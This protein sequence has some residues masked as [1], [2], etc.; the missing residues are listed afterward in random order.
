M[1]RTPGQIN[2]QALCPGT[3]SNINVPS[4]LGPDWF[5][6]MSRRRHKSPYRCP[7]CRD[8]LTTM[9]LAPSNII[10]TVF[11]L[12][13]FQCPH[14][15]TIFKRPFALIGRITG[16]SWICNKL[17][18]GTTRHSGTSNRS[19]GMMASPT[20]RR[21]AKFGRW[22]ESTEE[23]IVSA[24]VNVWQALVRLVWF[25]PGLFFKRRPSHRRDTLRPK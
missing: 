12:R 2:L 24:I 21:A 25:L 11:L 5:T 7:F 22:V 13:S 16:V 3:S 23:M 17:G 10:Q 8:R 9:D 19:E 6:T 15:F 4:R 1:W 18:G 20:T 14:C